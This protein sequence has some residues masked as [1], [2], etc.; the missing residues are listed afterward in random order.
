ML[1]EN[2]FRR[3]ILKVVI[4][5]G[6]L[7]SFALKSIERDHSLSISLISETLALGVNAPAKTVVFAGDNHLL[8]PLNF[9]QCAGRAGR[10]GF[11]TLGRVVFC[12]ISLDRIQRLLLSRLPKLGGTFPLTPTLVLR[13]NSLL[14]GSQRAV[15]FSVPLFL[16][17]GIFDLT[18]SSI[19]FPAPRCTVD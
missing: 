14:H 13:L 1:V 18:N 9:R 19:V 4:S 17:L 7:F 10:R 11:D 12:A 16:Y 15:R 5:T 3:G 8:T 6:A 2:F